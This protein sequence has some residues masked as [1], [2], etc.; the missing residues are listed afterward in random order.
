MIRPGDVLRH[1][2]YTECG[3]MFYFIVSI[4][5][6]AFLLFQIQPMIARYILPW[7]GG[8]PAVW[9][10]VQMFFQILLTAGYAY[11][12]WVSK[13]G[14]KRERWH[15]L[16]LCLSVIGVLML[17]V[18]WRSP[19]TP[20]S[21]WKPS[22]EAMPVLE[23]VKL[24]MIS[25]GLPYFLLASNS[26]LVQA[27]FHRL[28]PTQ[29]AYRLYA[30]SNIGSLLGLVSY[31]LLVEPL[32]TLPVQG[33][34]W[35]IGYLCY[36]GFALWG[37]IKALQHRSATVIYPEIEASDRPIR[38]SWSDRL[39]WIG[40]AATASLFLLAT[41]A[42]ITQEIAVVPFLWVL[43]LTIYLLSFII[44]FANE[45]YYN[46]NIFLGIFIFSFL[47]VIWAVIGLVTIPIIIQ[48]TIYSLCL[49]A[50]CMICHGELYRLRPQQSQLTTFYLLVSVG[51][52]L[53]GIFV[54][55]VAPVIFKGYWEYPLG[56]V[57]AWLLFFLT[58]FHRS[59]TGLKWQ[60]LMLWAGLICAGFLMYLFISLDLESSVLLQRNFYAATRIKVLEPT[61]E[62]SQRYV[63]VHGMTLHGVQYLDP[64]KRKLPTAYYS[65]TSGVGLAIN[66][67]PRR[68]NGMRVG[69]LGL[70]IGTLAAYGLP[71]DVY[72]F[73]EINPDVIE[74]AI[75][76]G[77]YFSYLQDSSA[78]IEVV[79]GDARLSL[80][81][82]LQESGSQN[83]HVLVLDVFSSDSI[84]VYLLNRE[85]F[86]LYL[87]H[88]APDG[89]IAVHISNRHLDLVPVVWKLAD[90]FSLHRLL[91]DDEGDN[92]RAIR[93]RWFLLSRDESL[94]SIPELTT[95]ARNMNGYT[96]SLPLWT[97][98]YSNLLQI[99]R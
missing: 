99:M 6:S 63:L 56:L 31:P 4:F 41:T 80:E 64:E 38:L 26:P 83:Y 94:L 7:F 32:F 46:R 27:W 72:R 33:W 1:A 22:P 75:G 87:D 58:T 44:T 57:L 24:L 15:I 16:L 17:S 62:S 13:P 82:E 5:L 3:N 74:I 71:D 68:R 55:F 35:S 2:I 53:G 39:L 73:Y 77:G 81:R 12:D 97:D 78:T 85:A 8:V 50:V 14:Y 65:E 42:R 84:P 52:A 95:R 89:I 47:A 67:H 28:F 43:P 60:R 37:T 20:S 19:I 76:K 34:M 54:T 92:E 36:V 98:D 88:L 79:L 86:A 40:L 91:I 70:G 23:I 48:I 30:I 18:F 9:S 10:T 93:S 49:F 51:G 66:H 59:E 29:T 21:D 90:H 61:N 96:T 25:V 11:A 69:V 45:R